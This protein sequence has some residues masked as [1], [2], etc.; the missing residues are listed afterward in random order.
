MNRSRAALE[1]RSDAELIR[2][3]R[4]DSVAFR[5]LYER[6]ASAMEQWIY[7]QTRDRTTARELLAETW[8]A[9]W[10]GAPRFR[11]GAGAQW[12]YG[13]ARKLL[14]Q[15]LRHHRVDTKA[16]KRLQMQ[17]MSWDDGE[18]DDVPSRLDA[19]KLSR[20]VREAFS[21][22]TWEQQKLLGLRVV[23]ER[24]YEEVA[25]ELGIS[26]T[27]ARVLVFQALQVLRRVIN[28]GTML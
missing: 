15:Y 1:R 28:K 23:G 5:V 13:V 9:V 16:R 18:L 22:L 20:G 21:E 11:G 12:L 4:R 17:S 26:Q 2:L 8:A 6:H 27:S 3:A 24:T 10:L 19:E 14:L 7:A 25:N